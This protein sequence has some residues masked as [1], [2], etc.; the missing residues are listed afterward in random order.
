VQLAATRTVLSYDPFSKLEQRR[1]RDLLSP[2]LRNHHRDVTRG[3]PV[4]EGGMADA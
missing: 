4:I 1:Y 3:D 2:L